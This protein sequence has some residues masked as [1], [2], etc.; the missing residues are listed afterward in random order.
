MDADPHRKEGGHMA[1]GT[2]TAPGSRIFISYRREDTEHPVGRLA[3]D[4]RKHFA[5]EQVFQ[6]IASIDPGVDFIDALQQG[7]DTCAAVLVVIGPRWLIAADAK[8]RR[9]LDLPD[10]WVRR[11]VAESLKR[12]GVRVFPVL[13]GDAD[14]PS[15]EDLPEP[16]R[17]LTRRQA[18]P[19]TVRH[20]N[21]DVAQFIDFLNKVPGLDRRDESPQPGAAPGGAQA[22]KRRELAWKPL[23]LVGGIGAI[24]LF[25]FFGRGERPLPPPA[26]APPAPSAPT[27]EPVQPKPPAEA[28]AKATAKATASFKAG[29]SFRDCEQCPEMV[30]VPAGD[31][32]MGSPATEKGRSDDE[33][34]QRKVSIARPFAAGK[35]EVTFAEWDACVEAGACKHKPGDQG[36]GRGRQPVINVSWEDV[37]A[38]VSWLSKKTSKR[39]RLLSEAEWEYAARAGTTTRYPW[40]DEPGTERANFGGSGSQWSGKQTAPVGSFEPNAFGLSDMIGNVWEWTQDCWSGNYSGAPNDGSALESGDCG[41]RVVRGGSW[42]YVPEYCRSAFRFWLEPGVRVN[43]MGFR[44]AR[45]L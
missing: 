32:M 28:T 43:L 37:Q 3:D 7:L 14:M 10:D 42:C 31:C 44:L 20:W 33:G 41:R 9:R 6:D 15:A 23:A 26:S 8:G 13:V 30:V 5:R 2:D 11:E 25:L 21:N 24:A 39:Y 40:G 4:L 12:P 22:R 16:L 17:P 19:L 29:E 27:A 36:W 1:A 38:Y 35:Y 45:T 18:F 34:P